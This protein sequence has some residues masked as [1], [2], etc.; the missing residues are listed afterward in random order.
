MQLR[1]TFGSAF[2]VA[3]P[4]SGGWHVEVTDF[5][6]QPIHDEAIRC[7]AIEEAM[8]LLSS[9]RSWLWYEELGHSPPKEV[10]HG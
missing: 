3:E 10:L 2:V 5:R 7:K 4:V 9:L 1:F 8:K 6:R